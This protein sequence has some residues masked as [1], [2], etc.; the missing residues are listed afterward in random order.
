MLCCL[1]LFKIPNHVAICPFQLGYF[2]VLM[3]YCSLP[4]LLIVLEITFVTRSI[5]PNVYPVPWFLIVLVLTFIDIF[6]ISWGFPYPSTISHAISKL[7]FVSRPI[8]PKVTALALKLALEVFALVPVSI[9]EELVPVATLQA[10]F[11]GAFVILR[12]AEDQS[13]E[14]IPL[15]VFPLTVIDESCLVDLFSFSVFVAFGKL[16]DIYRS[17]SGAI[18]SL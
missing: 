15:V 13:A 9:L 3:C 17:F 8:C 2:A 10:T 18:V 4:V 14:A 7:P 11:E 12:L 16:P 6:I 1:S 5:C